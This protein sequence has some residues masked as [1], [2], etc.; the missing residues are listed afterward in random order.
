MVYKA[1]PHNIPFHF[2]NRAMK[3]V[4]QWS[5]LDFKIINGIENQCKLYGDKGEAIL[6]GGNTERRGLM[7]VLKTDNKNPLVT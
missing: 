7:T 4:I 6:A 2:K 5:D 1:L 3:G